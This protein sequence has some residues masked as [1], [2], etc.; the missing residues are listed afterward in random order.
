LGAILAAELHAELATPHLALMLW[1]PVVDG[2]IHMNQFMRLR[3]AAQL[4]RPN[5]PKET[6]ASMRAS[7]ADGNTLEVS[8]YEVHPDLVRAIDASS[9]S[10]SSPVAGTDVLWLEHGAANSPQAPAPSQKVASQWSSANCSVALQT[11]EGPQFWQM[12]ERVV[13]PSIIE[14]TTEWFGRRMAPGGNG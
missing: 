11:Y 13:T 12:H 7:L 1:Q 4:D 8:G 5:L 9:L 3:I 14:L 6:T 2:K 10:A